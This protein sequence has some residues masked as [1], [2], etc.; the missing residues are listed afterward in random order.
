MILVSSPP[1]LARRGSSQ[2]SRTTKQNIKKA[3]AHYKRG[4]RLFGDEEYKAA[5]AEFLASNK[6]R[7]HWRT[8]YNIAT[9][10]GRLGNYVAAI[11][12]YKKSLAHRPAPPWGKRRGIKREIKRLQSLLAIVRISLNVPKATLTVGGRKRQVTNGQTLRLPSGIHV[13]EVRA[14]GY[15]PQRQKVTLT[16][17]SVSTVQFTLRPGTRLRVDSNEKGARVFIDGVEVGKT[18]YEA[19]VSPR[20]IGVRVLSAGRLPWSGQVRGKPGSTVKVDVSLDD[21]KGGLKQFW[22][23]TAAGTAVAIAAVALGLG[24]RAKSIQRDYDSVV[25]QIQTGNPSQSDLTTLQTEGRSLQ[26]DLKR[27][28]AGANVAIGLSAASAVTAVA[29]A[30]F[31][32]FRSPKSRATVSIALRPEG[33]AGIFALGR[34]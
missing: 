11:R 23:W 30:F 22:F 27:F 24:L 3:R 4:I 12:H 25:Q 31:T 2:A 29:L 1:L 8:L 6:L 33:G 32:R 10:Y 14:T 7:S 20:T 5:L 28:S 16:G 15:G 19:D 18:P 17:G 26:T 9:C 21:P 13:L 34:F